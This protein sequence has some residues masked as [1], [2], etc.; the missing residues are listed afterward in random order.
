MKA[1]VDAGLC[2]AH[3]QCNDICPEVFKIDEWGYAYTDDASVPERLEGA[4]RQ[5]VTA[6]P[7]RAITVEN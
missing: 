1:L 2:Q 5:A 3:G 6:C 7:E 4:V